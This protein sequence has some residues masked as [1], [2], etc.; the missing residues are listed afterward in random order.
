M[1]STVAAFRERLTQPW[2]ESAAQERV[3][4]CFEARLAE[5]AAR[6]EGD[7]PAVL[8]AESEPEA[9]LGGLLAAVA[10][11]APVFLAN[12]AWRENEWAQVAAQ[13]KPARTWGEVPLPTV[14]DGTAL[15]LSG[16]D[17]RPFAGHILIPT[18]GT[19]GRVRFAAHTWETL[20]AA[21][22]GYAAF[23][24]AQPVHAWCVL[25]LW[26]VSGLMQAVR[27]FR[28]GGRLVLGDYREMAAPAP[29]MPG[30]EAFH[31]SLV[32][33]QFG[34][35]LAR[36]GGADWLRGFGLILLGGAALPEDLQA[37]AR[38][39]GLRVAGSYGMTETA[40]MVAA[41][42]PEDFLAGEPLAGEVF[43]HAQVTVEDGEIT[44]RAASLFRGYY[45][46]HPT[47]RA[48]FRPG[49]EGLLDSQGRLRVIGRRDRLIISGGEKIDPLEVEAA[50]RRLA[51]GAEALVTGEP[52]PDW[53]QRVI[54]LVAGVDEAGLKA[55]EQALR[56]HLQPACLPKRWVLVEAL[57]LKPNGKLDRMRLA[58]LL[59]TAS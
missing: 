32:P 38:A 26:H 39:A 15:R 11:G 21:A 4:V 52:D 45:P 53:G 35:I 3:R 34:R 37:A 17:L 59:E 57:P 5:L 7:A 6:G 1:E 41:Q 27:T 40:A 54:A 30:R 8:L 24:H 2:L 47:L 31:L 33:T 23:F 10:A 36:E 44:I 50:I 20:G 51:P 18:G 12:P 42:R 43:P 48:E 56:G 22:G 14:A 49:D 46:E 16:P 28:T 9:F 29:G 13:L 19:G 58:Q 25:P 55:L